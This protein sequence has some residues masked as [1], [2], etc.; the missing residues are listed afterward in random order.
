MEVVGKLTNARV[1]D[2]LIDIFSEP[3]PL[4][5]KAVERLQD[6]GALHALHPDLAVTPA[7][8]ERYRTLQRYIG[9]AWELL[10]NAGKAWI[11]CMAAMLADL[12]S[13]ETEKWCH[14]MR[15]RREDTETIMQCLVRVPEIMAICVAE[16]PSTSR[17]VELLDPLND[18]ALAYLYALGGPQLRKTVVSYIK[19]WKNMALDIDGRD[20]TEMGLKPSRAFARI[21]NAVRA[22]ALDGKVNGR[23]EELELARELVNKAQRE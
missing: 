4:P 7:M 11:L 14:Q 8:R 19:K 23:E 21:L 10:G 15:F 6:L 2:E 18:E 5:F 20:L 22:E 17:I 16:K 13:Q 9:G 3:F 12:P 1:R